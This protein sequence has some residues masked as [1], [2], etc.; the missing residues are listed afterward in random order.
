MRVLQNSYICRGRYTHS[1][2]NPTKCSHSVPRHPTDLKQSPK[3]R[4]FNPSKTRSIEA[5]KETTKDVSVHILIATDAWMPQRNGV[6]RVLATLK[7]H[8]EQ[9]GHKITLIE[10][11]VFKTIPCPSYSEI[12]LALFPKTEIERRLDDL[13]PDAIHIAS[14]GPIGW[15]MR[16]ICLK[17]KIPFTTAYHTK[18]PEYVNARTK[19]PLDWIYSLMRFF[20]G[21]AQTTLAPSPSVYRELCARRF[22]GV[23]AWAHGVDTNVFAPNKGKFFDLP[24]PI[25]MYVGRVTIDK[26][27]GEFLDLD[28]PGSKVIVGDGPSRANLKA[29]YKDVTFHIAENDQQ[30]AQCYCAADVFVF[31]SKTDTFGLV[32]LEALASGVP[33]A[34][35]PVTGPLD[36]FG[37]TTAGETNFGVLDADL[38]KAAMRALGKS[39]SACRDHAL[40][41]SWET[42]AD[43][44]LGA[45]ALRQNHQALRTL[46][47]SHVQNGQVRDKK[48]HPFQMPEQ[49][50]SEEI[51][52]SVLK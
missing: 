25:F 33:V 45:L 31:P 41:F 39:P 38:G 23:R 18:F 19:L 32:M 2:L 4:L 36:V 49:K 37:L 14:E 3:L 10:P 6:V 16:A 43:E 8:L 17:R 52:P 48:N 12:P 44:F 47:D 30:L 40:K 51:Q 50:E 21:P 5:V 42:V 13:T 7:S 24:G 46:S 11:G 27:L 1:F 35:L 28:L 9:R 29:R 26:N 22:N 20:H 34:A 15:A